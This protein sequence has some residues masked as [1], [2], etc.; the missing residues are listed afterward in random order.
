MTDYL[1]LEHLAGLTPE[2]RRFLLE[3]SVLDTM[4]APLC[5]ALLDRDDSALML[6]ELER[7]NLFVIP[8]DHH[9]EWYRYHHLFRDVL[10]NELA[11]VEPAAASS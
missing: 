2:R 1:R 10:R 9:R 3:T 11:R 4:C 8:L 6:E 5:D 7:A